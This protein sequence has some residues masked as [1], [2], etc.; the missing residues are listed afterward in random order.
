ME[1]IYLYVKNWKNAQLKKNKSSIYDTLKG[2][3]VGLS[4]ISL[5][6]PRNK[7]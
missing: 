6:F 4:F 2:I 5:L 7:A 3:V 1:S